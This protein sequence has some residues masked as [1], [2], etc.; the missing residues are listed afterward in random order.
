[1]EETKLDMMQK[2]AVHMLNDDQA[3]F[4]DLFERRDAQKAS[5]NEEQKA[6]EEKAKDWGRERQE[7]TRRLRRNLLQML[8]W[9]ALGIATVVAVKAQL[10]HP[11]IGSGVINI[12]LLSEGWLFRSAQGTTKR[13][14]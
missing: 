7:R 10:V 3:A 5:K 6:R 11:Y 12:C 4:A 2:N 1:M 13:N 9:L 14:G 8:A